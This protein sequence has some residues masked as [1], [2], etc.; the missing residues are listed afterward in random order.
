MTAYYLY[1]GATGTGTGLSKTNAFTDIATAASTIAAGDDL[2]VSSAHNEATTNSP[3][4]PGTYASPN[5]ILCVNFA[6]STPPVAADITTGALINIPS[7]FWGINGCF[8][9][10]GLQFYSVAAFQFL[11]ICG[12][13]ANSQTY[14]TS[15]FR[16][17]TFVSLLFGQGPGGSE[18]SKVRWINCTEILDGSN[19]PCD[20]HNDAGIIFEW[21]GGS[22]T[23]T[24]NSTF[25]SENGNNGQA[26]NFISLTGV[27]FSL[28]TSGNT[29]FDTFNAV[30]VAQM[31]DCRLASGVTVSAQQTNPGVTIDLICSDSGATNYR[32]ER[33]GYG[34]ILTTETTNIL[35]G[36]AALP[37]SG[38]AYSQKIVTD[39]NANMTFPFIGFAWPE[40]Y[41]GSTGSSISQ[42]FD[43][44]TDNVT[45]TN[46]NCWIEMVY[47]GNASYPL[48][49]RLSTA[50]ATVL[51]TPTNLTTSTA[52]W[53]TTGIT[54]P[55]KQKIIAT[56][57]PQ[58]KGLYYPVLKVGIASTTIW[59]N[60][61]SAK[62]A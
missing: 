6:G 7:G 8:Y 10:Y 17:G 56:W 36:G 2:Y 59:F 20:L 9:C 37:G 34:G 53:V 16:L 48:G 1:S 4:F 49:S 41:V 43:V 61:P 51:T 32:C 42:E 21:I 14:D 33:Y 12:G 3:Q 62:A 26:P 40:F 5:R 47:L 57:T 18:T 44:L 15:I 46:A 54:T 19:G 31:V 11:N 35:T 28:W 25:F 38:Q 13:P 60:P 45:L 22:V 23:G 55:V 29:I 52:S 30:V 27:D 58:L 39:S 24:V 50:P